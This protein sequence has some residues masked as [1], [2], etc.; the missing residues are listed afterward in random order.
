VF[1]VSSYAKGG[2]GEFKLHL[3]NLTQYAKRRGARMVMLFVGHAPCH[4][5]KKVEKFIHSRASRAEVE[6]ADKEGP[7][8]NPVERLVNKPLRSVVCT[9]P[10]CSDIHDVTRAG[11]RLSRNIERP[12]ELDADENDGNLEG[13]LRSRRGGGAAGPEDDAGELDDASE[14]G[15]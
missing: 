1:L 11:R 13:P 14:L 8:L 2:T 5:T 10:P 4:K 12:S 7:N 9:N 3:S 6:D 15:L